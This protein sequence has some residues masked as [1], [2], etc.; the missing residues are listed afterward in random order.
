MVKTN[1]NHYEKRIIRLLY[2]TRIAATAYEISKALN[3]SYITCKKYLDELV[4]EKVL[5]FFT[6]KKGQKTVKRF[7]FRFEL[8]DEK[9]NY[10]K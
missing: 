4:K 6:E 3:I 1:Y 5:M 9:N 2:S 7:V 8:V 10:K